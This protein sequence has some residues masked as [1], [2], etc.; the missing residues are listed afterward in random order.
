M[1]KP[2]DSKE[3]RGALAACTALLQTVGVTFARAASWEPVLSR[4]RFL[5]SRSMLGVHPMFTLAL[6]FG[7][8]T[9]TETHCFIWNKEDKLELNAIVG[10]SK[11][12]YEVL[13]TRSRPHCRRLAWRL[14]SSDFRLNTMKKLICYPPDLL[15]LFSLGAKR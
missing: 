4:R 12:F 15:T 11:T 5:W 6:H 9:G 3:A 1:L 10:E 2:S 7:T 13:R 14:V 8:G